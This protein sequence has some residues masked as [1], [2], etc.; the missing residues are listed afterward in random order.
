MFSMGCV[1][2]AGQERGTAPARNVEEKRGSGMRRRR[3]RARA[4]RRYWMLVG[5][6]GLTQGSDGDV[7]LNAGA[8]L[9][10]LREAQRTFVN[11]NMLTLQLRDFSHLFDEVRCMLFLASYTGRRTGVFRVKLSFA[12]T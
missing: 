10:S 7:Y 8:R 6:C 2:M 1:G 11:L 12:T 9:T 3:S 4:A 5:W